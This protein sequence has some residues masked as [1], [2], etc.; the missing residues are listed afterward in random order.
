MY[1]MFKTDAMLF[2]IHSIPSRQAGSN[3]HRLIKQYDANQLR[4]PALHTAYKKKFLKSFL[5]QCTQNFPNQNRS[6]C[7]M[8]NH[9]T[10][11][12][13]MSPVNSLLDQCCHLLRLEIRQ[14]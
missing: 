11:R 14:Q 10:Y 7:G 8:T 4:F 2:S 3:L 6:C 12:G 1:V 9:F 5:L 13:A